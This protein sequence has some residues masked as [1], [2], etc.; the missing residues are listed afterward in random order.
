MRPAP[1]RID[2]DGTGSEQLKPTFT[3][4]LN[5]TIGHDLLR[6]SAALARHLNKSRNL[7]S[8]RTGEN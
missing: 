5:V 8:R 1:L 4:C 7:P 3:L 2:L 6:I